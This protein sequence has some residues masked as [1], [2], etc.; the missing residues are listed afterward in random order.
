MLSSTRRKDIVQ[1]RHIAIFLC[2]RLTTL[3][4]P[5]MGRRFG[6]RDHTTIL[7]AIRKVEQSLSNSDD[8]YRDLEIL[9][10]TL[11]S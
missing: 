1:A 3:S 4:M 2:K 9:E 5:D 7:H 11:K 8:A 6:G 10:K